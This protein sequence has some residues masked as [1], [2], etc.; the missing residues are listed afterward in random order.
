MT[1]S[2]RNETKRQLELCYQIP[3]EFLEKRGLNFE[4]CRGQDYDTDSSMKA[5]YE[6]VKGSEELNEKS[7]R[8]FSAPMGDFIQSLGVPA[9]VE[10]LSRSF[11]KQE[12]TVQGYIL[13]LEQTL[14]GL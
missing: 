13:I 11:D 14:Y 4:D 1:G 7:R 2:R 5:G 10:G 6:S 12:A 3:L 9:V 8:K